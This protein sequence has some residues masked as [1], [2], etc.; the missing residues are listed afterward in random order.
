[1]TASD[2]SSDD[3]FGAR[4]RGTLLG[5]EVA[6]RAVA[7]SAVG[8][9]LTLYLTPALAAPR[10]ELVAPLGV[11][12]A[13]LPT[14][15]AAALA[16]RGRGVIPAVVLPFGPLAGYAL[17]ALDTTVVGV[18][19]VEALGVALAGAT[20]LGLAAYVVGRGAALLLRS[21]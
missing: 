15:G 12:V 21:A 11:A 17:Y 6:E 14:L 1:M 3:E 18:P 10:P 8:F 13:L 16:A 7:W 5:E 9:F 20:A 19:Y 4:L 2:T